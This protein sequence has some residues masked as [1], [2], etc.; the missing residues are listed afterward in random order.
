[1]HETVHV[2]LYGLVAAASPVALL[3]TLVVL[4]SG[5]GRIN[6]VAFAGAF[7]LGQSAAFVAAYL[8]GSAATPDDGDARTVVAALELAAGLLLIG[9]AWRRRAGGAP[10]APPGAP[11]TDALFARL[12]HVTPVA[13]VGVGLPLGVGVKRL[14]LTVLAA[15]TIATGGLEPSED[16]ALALLYLALAGVVVWAPVVLYV[17]FGRR[18]DRMF[19]DA[20]RWIGGHEERLTVVSAVVLGILLVGDALLGLLS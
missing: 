5:R 6:G 3:A 18:A 20:R 10:L 12:S 8:V 2:A 9:I 4:G 13:A 1:M 15:S 16:A 17:V 11:R 19:D 14:V 7:L